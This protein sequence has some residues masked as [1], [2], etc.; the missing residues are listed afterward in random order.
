MRAQSL[1]ASAAASR[2]AT[3]SSEIIVKTICVPSCSL[4]ISTFIVS[5]RF[6]ELQGLLKRQWRQRTAVHRTECPDFIELLSNHERGNSIREKSLVVYGF[7]SRRIF[8]NAHGG[9]RVICQR[10]GHP[11]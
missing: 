2:A 6:N 7:F 1:K 8:S 5:F 10:Q 11:Y 4:T 3:S 9:D